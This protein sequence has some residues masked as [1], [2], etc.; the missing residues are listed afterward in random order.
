MPWVEDCKCAKV[1][2]LGSYLVYAW[3]QPT[4]FV[5]T[6]GLAVALYSIEQGWNVFQ[7]VVCTVP[8]AAPSCRPRLSTAQRHTAVLLSLAVADAAGAGRSYRELLRQCETDIDFLLGSCLGGDRALIEG[9]INNR[10]K[11]ERTM[12]LVP[13]GSG[14]GNKQLPRTTISSGKFSSIIKRHM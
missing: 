14:G 12:D 1:Q 7:P 4:V 10:Q 13:R 3:P 11:N 9:Q 5:Y 2:Q 8:A 6:T